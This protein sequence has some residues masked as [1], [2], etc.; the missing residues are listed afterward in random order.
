MLFKGRKRK[1]FL[2]AAIIGG[3]SVG[4]V[5]VVMGGHFFSDIIVSGFMVTST[6]YF[7]FWLFYRQFPFSEKPLPD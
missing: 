4:M 6:A 5:R 3:F 1:A 7:M 2:L